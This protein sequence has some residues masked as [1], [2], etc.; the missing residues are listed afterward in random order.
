M[1][2]NSAPVYGFLPPRFSRVESSLLRRSSRCKQRTAKSAIQLFS[3]LSARDCAARER[4]L[5]AADSC[6]FSHNHSLWSADP[7][8]AP[9]RPMN[10][11]V[12]S[13]EFYASPESTVPADFYPDTPP[14]CEPIQR[15][16]RDE[17]INETLC[18]STCTDRRASSHKIEKLPPPSFP[19]FLPQ[20]FT[21]IWGL[22]KTR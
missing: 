4:I 5:H 7:D 12:M 15:I 13:P 6:S 19:L 18:I 9:R 1:L 20:G 2:L 22:S 21:T 16:R 17:T 11:H 10:W 14:R 8:L 3:A